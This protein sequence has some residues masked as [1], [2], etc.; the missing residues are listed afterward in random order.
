MEPPRQPA[1]ILAPPKLLA[2]SNRSWLGC[3]FGNRKPSDARM[4]AIPIPRLCERL[5]PKAALALPCMSGPAEGQ[6][7]SFAVAPWRA[8]RKSR[9]LPFLLPE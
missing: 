9:R 7:C 5:W 8:P 4:P 1:W 2:K 3:N 6:S